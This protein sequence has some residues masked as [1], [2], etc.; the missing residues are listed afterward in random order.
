MTNPSILE[1]K[2]SIQVHMQSPH[3]RH[4]RRRAAIGARTPA[5]SPPALWTSV[6]QQRC[7]TGPAA[8]CCNLLRAL[9]VGCKA[10][11]RSTPGCTLLA[12]AGYRRTRNMPSGF[13]GWVA[14]GL[15]VDSRPL[16]A[17]SA[18]DEGLSQA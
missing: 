6:P 17:S 1:P 14:A 18:P 11:V 5:P 9:V 13:D 15:P 2:C 10:G 4:A 16:Q 12:Q 8:T 3:A 7:K